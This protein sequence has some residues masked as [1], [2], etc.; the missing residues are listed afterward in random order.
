MKKLNV[1]ELILR[2]IRALSDK[3]TVEVIDKKKVKKE[4]KYTVWIDGLMHDKGVFLIQGHICDTDKVK[5]IILRTVVGENALMPQ[6]DYT[7][8][9]G[10]IDFKI[11]SNFFVFKSYHL[12]SIDVVDVKGIV[13]NTT[14]SIS[15]LGK[16]VLVFKNK[17]I[18]FSKTDFCIDVFTGDYGQALAIRYLRERIDVDDSL[19]I[20][21][22][23]ITSIDVL[24]RDTDLIQAFIE[25]EYNSRELIPEIQ[26][27][28][29]CY[30]HAALN[31]ALDE[32]EAIN[33][34]VKDHSAIWDKIAGI[35]RMVSEER[36]LS[37]N[38]TSY[39]KDFMLCVRD[40][41]MSEKNET[42]IDLNALSTIIYFI[43]AD[44][45]DICVEGGMWIPSS[46]VDKK[47]EPVAD[48]NGN[49]INIYQINDIETACK[50]DRVYRKEIGFR[51]KIEKN[52]SFGNIR[53][54][55]KIA[56]SYI[57]PINLRYHNLLCPIS[58]RTQR[59]YYYS[60]EVLFKANK[61]SLKVVPFKK[62]EIS[63]YEQ[64][65]RKEIL[66][67]DYSETD[68]QEIIIIRDFYYLYNYGFD[69]EIYKDLMYRMESIRQKD[70]DFESAEE[71]VEKYIG[72]DKS[73]FKRIWLL[74][75]R[76]DRADDNAEALFRYLSSVDMS[77]IDVYFCLQHK[78]TEHEALKEFGS[79]I[80]PLSLSHRMLHCIAEFVISSQMQEFVV[81]PYNDAK[82]FLKDIIR[83]PK[84]VF[85]QHGVTHNANGQILGRYGRNFYGIIVSSRREYDYIASKRFHY[86]QKNV[87]LTGMPRFDR[88]YTDD[89]KQ[90]TIMPTWRKWLTTREF[91]NKTDTMAWK[92]NESSFFTSEY[93]TFY[94]SLIN[95][96]ELLSAAKRYGY[97]IAFLPHVHFLKYAHVFSET[98][99]VKVYDY[100]ESYRK[101]FAESSLVVTDYSSVAF[102]FSYLYKP[103]VYCQFDEEKFYKNHTVKKGYFD[104]EK[105]GFGEVA[106]DKENLVEIIIDYIKN[107]CCLKDMYKNRID[108]FF[109]FH[110][111]KCCESIYKY[112]KEV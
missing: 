38:M 85:L 22:E 82:D 14:I 77:G 50:F 49:I 52:K 84:F 39:F 21:E 74:M 62:T 72:S 88:L 44:E 79:I 111:K 86:L 11:N 51:L 28:I 83:H 95:D 92:V 102:D 19:F 4:K 1:V 13:R 103:V 27:G 90:I 56:D 20:P 47:V 18:W 69:E 75:D 107:D 16:K 35:L 55:Y 76:P 26:N 81:N 41:G 66:Q 68:I 61:D 33:Q 53:F 40:S 108:D 37:L 5:E 93:F 12:F 45:R 59:G 25:K 96:V 87:W 30:F 100:E 34:G 31:N 36:I 73:S 106:R 70:S 78:S 46:V 32:S 9:S 104:F 64:Y 42:R 110:D 15:S 65:F 89:K 109:V 105:D 29:I 6:L 10:R 7:F 48:L 43:T 57:F 112:L 58:Y 63:S 60:D 67:A 98:E 101:V 8:E 3:D 71:I 23:G 2:K 91:D 97:T 80:E 54:G 99:D 17:F 94:K 24:E